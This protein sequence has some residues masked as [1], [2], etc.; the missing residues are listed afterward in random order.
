VFAVRTPVGQNG[1]Y[2]WHSPVT[3]PA[4]SR[5]LQCPTLSKCMPVHV[6]DMRVAADTFACGVYLMVSSADQQTGFASFRRNLQ[7]MVSLRMLSLDDLSRHGECS[8]Q[9]RILSS[10][11]YT[12]LLCLYHHFTAR[13]LMGMCAKVC[14]HAKC[15]CCSNSIL[16]SLADQRPQHH[17]PRNTYH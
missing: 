16:R 7:C 4:V 10:K 11:E 17:V 1:I 6:H 9:H 15:G 13:A 14:A 8:K 12:Q 2:W 5:T 3:L